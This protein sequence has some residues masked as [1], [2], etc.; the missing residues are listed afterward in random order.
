MIVYYVNGLYYLRKRGQ[1]GV[2]MKLF[3]KLRKSLRFE[4]IASI[5]VIILMAGGLNA[6]ITFKIKDL[7]NYVAAMD[8]NTMTTTELSA[9]VMQ[10]K[11]IAQNIY[12]VNQSTGI[13]TLIVAI[14]IMCML[15]RIIVTPTRKA[16]ARLD[17]IIKNIQES[18]GD[19]TTR[20]ET[21]KID[22]IGRLIQGINHFIEQL[23][24]VMLDI[25]QHSGNLQRSAA[26]VSEQTTQA[27]DRISSISATME[28]LSATMEE[29]ASTVTE[30][31][32]GANDIL[33]TMGTF[34]DQT[35]QGTV[36]AGEMKE[37]AIQIQNRA[38]NSHVSAQNMV[39]NITASLDEALENSR[40]VNKIN[41][42]TEDILSI[43]SQTN[44]LALNASIEAARAGDAGRG[45]A[46]V[47][48]QIRVLA[49]SSKETANSIQ[50][51]SGLVIDAVQQLSNNATQM[52]TF[53]DETVMKDYEA[54]LDGTQHYQD[55][56]VNMARTME[57]FHQ[58]TDTLTKTLAD[59]TNGINGISN[60]MMDSSRGVNEAAEAIGE[61]NSGMA[62][63]EAESI[64]TDTI[65]IALGGTVGR[66]Q[67]I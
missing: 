66:F 18:E 67:T 9:S 26:M 1:I 39:S 23:Q 53:T 31:D 3:N 45:F 17:E 50:E 33:Q 27:S 64:K 32:A 6:Y 5:M 36:F 22:E 19:L 41:E 15:V 16:T 10:L 52:L 20:I 21:K 46:V 54:F 42:L 4:V 28:E 63:I 56:A 8:P 13:I 38:A 40:N 44:L 34:A 37:R 14:L 24:T 12:S 57:Y 49:D 30:M 51:I 11:N 58:Q 29:V 60:S 25:K 43:A 48:D 65:S 2:I 35:N 62:D 47:A 7:Q 55:D 61:I 59:M